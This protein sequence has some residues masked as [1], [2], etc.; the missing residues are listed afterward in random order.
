MGGTEFLLSCLL[1]ATQEGRMIPFTEEGTEAQA[2]E[3]LA[4]GHT[5]VRI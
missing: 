3:E 5:A 1:P 2:G 4:Q